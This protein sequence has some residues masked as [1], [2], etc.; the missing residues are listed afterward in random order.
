VEGLG[1]S[2][3]EV[4]MTDDEAQIAS[5]AALDEPLR[6]SL[7]RYVVGQPAPVNREQ[8]AAGVGV[9]LH[10]AKFHL[11]RLVAEGL[12]DVGYARPPGRGGPG[13]GRP[14]K[15][16]RRA[17]REI[18][19]TLPERHYD[20]AGDVLA[21][22]VETATREGTPVADALAVRARA[23]G[24]EL[25]GEGDVPHDL[26]Q[27]LARVGYEPR[28]DEGGRLVLANC[29]FHRLAERHTELVCGMNLDLIGGLLEGLAI[30]GLRAELD[31][32]P[33]RCCVVI[34]PF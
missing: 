17:D 24:R 26:P 3:L 10:A 16:Y 18:A 22:A 2:D 7:Y 6:R 4:A 9:P 8:A 30:D 23:A 34:S 11:D 14:A 20:L 15:L 25:G 29:P 1:R 32:A 21:G 19:V 28:A 5:V 33:G 27:A 12:L 13:A 31:P